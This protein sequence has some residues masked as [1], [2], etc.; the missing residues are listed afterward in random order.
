M[1]RFYKLVSLVRDSGAYAVQL[2]G[3]SVKTPAGQALK[4]EFEALAN[5]LV[6][7]WAGQGENILPDSMPL[8]Q[9]LSTKIDRA[10]P[11][12][13]EIEKQALNYLD[14]DL[15]CYRAENPPGLPEKQASIWDPHLAR[16]EKRF[17]SRLET[18]TSLRALKQPAAAHEAVRSYARVLDDDRFNILQLVTSM[19]GSLILALA[20]VEGEA[21]AEE[22][23]SAARVEE[24]FK[25]GLYN[26]A[27]YGPD[28][29]QEKKDVAIR[30]DLEAAQ[31]YLRLL[32][33]L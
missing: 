12:R 14:T 25:A 18:T 3:R 10:A 5:A 26:E 30:R 31:E 17:G 23:F 6:S 29:A 22:V 1:K 20:F 21:S 2:D 24:N 28:P 9:I 16:F 7:E 13:A 11:M 33:K 8:T 4:T 19:S 27:L 32:K 15:L